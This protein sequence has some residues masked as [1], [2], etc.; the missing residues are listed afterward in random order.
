[1]HFRGFKFPKTEWSPLVC[2][3]EGG[4]TTI[5]VDGSGGGSPASSAPAA[6]SGGGTGGAASDSPAS[7]T[8][9]ATPSSNTES[10]EGGDFWGGLGKIDFDDDTLE[11]PAA[12]PTAPA[13]PAVPAQA[14]PV[15][16]QPQQPVAPAPQAQ[17]QSPP[18]TSPQQ[19]Q[20]QAATPMPSVG[21]PDK[22]AEWLLQPQNMSAAVDALAKERFNLS[23]DDVR[24]I[25]TDV[26][27]FIPKMFARAHVQAVTSVMKFLSQSM[28]EMHRNLS[29]ATRA[30]DEAET[31][32]FSAVKGLDRTNAQHRKTAMQVVKMYRGMNPDAN[33]DQIIQVC[34]P[35]IQHALGNPAPQAPQPGAPSAARPVIP[36]FQPAVGAPPTQP[37]APEADPWGGLGGQFDA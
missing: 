32:F 30:N 8:P 22:L 12:A 15:Q 6:P 5:S 35:M 1:M 16:P 31:K 33:M 3:N 27:A 18:P 14:A 13:A 20:P 26:V 25:E 4:G 17:P 9:A 24:E 36:A 11:I 28:P 34:G 29:Q 10:A 19:A 23:E 21:E 7:S 37:G 2:E